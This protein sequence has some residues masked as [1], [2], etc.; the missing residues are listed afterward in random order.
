VGS[1]VRPDAAVITIL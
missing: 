1:S